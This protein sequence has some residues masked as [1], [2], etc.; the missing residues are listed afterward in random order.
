MF[1]RL[2]IELTGPICTCAEQK[3]TWGIVLHKKAD[4]ASA[5]GLRVRCGTC[6]TVLEVPPAKFLACFSLDQ[7]Y[8]GTAAPKPA[9]L[10]E[11]PGGRGAVLAF[12]TTDDK[13]E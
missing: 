3:L 13:P 8:P 11:I 2:T 1:K 7:K 4:G 6:L 9:P 10:I 12:P 5:H